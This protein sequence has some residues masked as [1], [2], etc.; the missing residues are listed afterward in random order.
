MGC[1]FCKNPPVDETPSS[2]FAKTDD[3]GDCG[4]MFH[5]KCRSLRDRE[6][7]TAI[8]NGNFQLWLKNNHHLRKKPQD[9]PL[10]RSLTIYY[11]FKESNYY[12]IKDGKTKRPRGIEF[13]RYWT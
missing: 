1:L 4:D 3:K 11:L 10:S 6:H 7:I 8:R 9:I 2:R 13:L 12:D 5:H